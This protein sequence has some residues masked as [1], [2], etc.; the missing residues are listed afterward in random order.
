MMAEYVERVASR[1][2]SDLVSLSDEE[3]A[4]GMQA[5]RRYGATAGART[6]PA[7]DIDLFVMR[8]LI[9]QTNG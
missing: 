8:R 9:E 5:L 2:L 4:S 1:A 3:F 6:C 7:I